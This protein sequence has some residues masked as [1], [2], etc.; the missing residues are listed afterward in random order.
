[1]VWLLFAYAKNANEI[2]M[3]IWMLF[4]GLQGGAAYVNVLYMVLESKEITKNEKEIATSCI[5]VMDDVGITFSSLLELVL[6]ST[7]LREQ[8]T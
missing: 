2:V 4:V 1:M 6:D 7:L 8:G 5:T 3:M